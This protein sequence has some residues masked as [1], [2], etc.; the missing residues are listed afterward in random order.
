MDS[1]IG[2][3]TDAQYEAQVASSNSLVI[4]D[5]MA[6]WCGPCHQMAPVLEEIASEHSEITIAKM[7]IDANP[8]K[9]A[10]R[11]GIRALPTFLFLKNGQ[12]VRREFGV[13]TKTQMASIVEGYLE[14]K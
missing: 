11:L 7:D 2:Y 6:D 12:E 9:V 1:K 3:F 4:V 5:F 14:A 8:S 13:L 10:K